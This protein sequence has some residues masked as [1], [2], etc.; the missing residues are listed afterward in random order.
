M[1]RVIYLTGF[2][3]L[4]TLSFFLFVMI[5]AKAYLELLTT[6]FKLFSFC[7]SWTTWSNVY[8]F[9]MIGFPLLGA[10]IG[11]KQGK[12]WWQRVYGNVKN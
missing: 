6:N 1:K 12:Y 9:S 8:R 4:G 10:Y 5:G 7:F 2:A 3:I 11:L